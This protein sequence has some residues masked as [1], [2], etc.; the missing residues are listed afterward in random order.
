MSTFLELKTRI[1]SDLERELTDET[2][3]GRTWDTEIGAADHEDVGLHRRAARHEDTERGPE[4]HA[5]AG[6]IDLRE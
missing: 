1:A 3:T 6:L 5:P 2:F 4:G